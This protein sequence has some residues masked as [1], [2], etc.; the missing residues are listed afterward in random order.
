[1][2]TV[3]GFKDFVGK[4][5]EER[6]IIIE[7]IRQT[8]ERYGF[9]P[10]ETP[11]VE[12]EEFVLG[13]NKQDEAVRDIFR[14]QDRGKR[15][16]A[17]RFEFT[18]QLKR[19]AKNQKLPFKRYQLGYN[20]R[21]EPIRPGRTRQFIQ[22]DADVVGSTIKN[23]AENI[24]LVNEILKNLKIDST[25][26]IN[27]RK[28]MDEIVEKEG[29]KQKEEVIREIDKLDKLSKEE[30]KNNL[31]KYN[32]ENLVEIF[33]KPED[34]YK[35]YNSYAEVEELKKYCKMFG[36]NVEFRP[37]LARGLSYY[38]GMV[39]EVWSKKLPVSI[40]GGGSY[41]V[42]DNQATG[43]SFGIEPLMLLTNLKFDLEKFL[44]VSLNQDKKAIQLSKQLRKQGKNTSV[45]FGKPNK[46]MAYA[47]SYNF[48]KVIFVGEKEVQKKKFKIKNLDTGKEI[49]LVISKA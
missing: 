8:F 30:V 25:I 40:L 16:L 35:K 42:G 19:I 31:K 14:L 23:E 22:C 10:A 17:L 12:Y 29:I 20:F 26:F 49:N 45:Y 6:A 2:E 5:A 11:I 38:N 27:N 15:K 4:E 46:A 24:S 7:I 21:D 13:K 33:T 44:V 18:F 9:Q 1:M 28:L 37:F 47:N 32:A 36:A 41:M 48:K 3:K 43:I 39:V 34:F